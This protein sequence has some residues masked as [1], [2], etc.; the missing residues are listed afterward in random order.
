MLTNLVRAAN[1]SS[2]GKRIPQHGASGPRCSCRIDV[3]CCIRV[4]SVPRTAM[5]KEDWVSMIREAIVKSQEQWEI[6]ARANTRD[7][8]YEARLWN[9]KS[10]RPMRFGMPGI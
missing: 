3:P 9:A 2:T 6:L 7:G 5:T 1:A 10:G 8:G 4:W